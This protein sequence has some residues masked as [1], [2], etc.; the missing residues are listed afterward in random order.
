MSLMIKS[1]Y[2]IIFI[3][4]YGLM[5]YFVAPTFGKS[6]TIMALLLVAC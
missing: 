4:F 3:G 1:L 5:L 6:Y 2:W